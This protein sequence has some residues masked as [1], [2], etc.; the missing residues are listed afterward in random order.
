MNNCID[1]LREATL[2][3]AVDANSGFW[4][5]KDWRGSSEQDC[6]HISFRAQAFCT[7]SCQK[8]DSFTT[9][10]KKNGLNGLTPRAGVQTWPHWLHLFYPTHWCKTHR[11]YQTGGKALARCR[12]STYPEK[13]ES[14]EEIMKYL[15]NVVLPS[16]WKNMM[17]TTVVIKNQKLY[18]MLPS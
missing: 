4:Q 11:S 17:H 3:S 13:S 10:S 15:V 6:L 7:S 18:R 1:S 9:V 12:Y 5:K 16:H 8:V 14:I 2:F